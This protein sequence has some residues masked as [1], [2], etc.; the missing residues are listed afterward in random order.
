MTEPTQHWE[1]AL[2][3]PGS[4]NAAVFRSVLVFAAVVVAI[5]AIIVNF[6]R[7]QLAAFPQFATFHAGFVFLVDAITSFVL[8]EQF[9]YQRR[10]IYAILGCAYL[11][12]SLVSI[13]FL[14][15]FPGALRADGLPVM[16]GKQSSVWV[17]HIWHIGFPALMALALLGHHE[18]GEAVLP[19]E[20]VARLTLAAVAAAVALTLATALAVSTFHD[21]LPVLIDGERHPLSAAFYA[22]G[23]VA[24][25]VT[26]VAM[27]MA[28]RLGWQRRTILHLWL[29]AVLT[30]SLADVAASLGA[31]T[32]FSLG[33]YFGRVE[34]MLA[35]SILLLVFLNE[36]DR[37]YRHI[38]DALTDLYHAN[39]QLKHSIEER[40]ALVA[41][42]RR[43]E[44]Q[45]R[46]LAY[47]D[48]LTELPN[49]RLLLDR[50]GQALAQARRHHYSMAVMFLDLDRFKQIND[51]LGHEAG[52]ELLKQV[53][54]RWKGCM[55]SG[56]TVCRSGGDEFIVV[57]PEITQPQ[58]AAL[59]AA[60]M[61]NALN[62]PV[63]VGAHR[64][65]VTTSIGIAVYPVDGADDVQ[66]LMRKAD[67]AMY[68]AKA[69]GRN[70]Y[71]F[72][73]E[74]ATDTEGADVVA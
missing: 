42:L 58:D 57:L 29:A 64:M 37:L 38:S 13:P 52:D 15:S 1:L 65:H 24:A 5:G 4:A 70:R 2:D 16:G 28:W 62:E 40:D 35:A 6:G 30:A 23:G 9:R 67:T 20:R 46:Q 18:R 45:V 10:P 71:C 51:T 17:W 54:V 74:V 7:I 8:F 14:L 56:D 11:F 12:S 21:E 22:T 36:A 55:R 66:E 3:Q 63:A 26:L 33:W 72:Y 53:A 49:R 48:S 39:A 31:Y 50:I 43:S 44:E 69:Q 34:S 25:A 73:G 32:R 59:V 19:R 68:A 27:M 41:Q 61:V 60:K 47:Y